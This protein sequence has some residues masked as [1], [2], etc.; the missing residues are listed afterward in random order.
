ML[1]TLGVRADFYD[2]CLRYPELADALQH[3]HM[4][5]GPLTT[6][7][8]R[9]AVTAPARAV[10]MELEPGLAE[11]IIREVSNDSPRGAHDA[12]VY[13]RSSPT[14]CSRPGSAARRAG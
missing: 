14:P 3:R 6:A 4:V 10:G 8:L 1:V 2:R 11:L 7:E 9:E 13:C 5:L 12:G